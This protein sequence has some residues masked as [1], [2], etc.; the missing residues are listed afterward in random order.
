MA[1]A[2]TASPNAVAVQARVV[3]A[4]K[5][6][7]V[8]GLAPVVAVPPLAEHDTVAPEVAEDTMGETD[9]VNVP[10]PGE[11]VGVAV[12]GVVDAALTVM[13]QG[14]LLSPLVDD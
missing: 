1:E 14:E 13:V 4:V 7:N 12:V 6:P 2:D 8:A 11:K 9:P 10:C 3:V 5:G